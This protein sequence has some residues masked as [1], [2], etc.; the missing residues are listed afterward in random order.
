MLALQRPSCMLPRGGRRCLRLRASSV[1]SSSRS[2]VSIQ[3]ENPFTYTY[4]LAPA[5][6]SFGGGAGALSWVVDSALVYQIFPDRFYRLNLENDVDAASLNDFYDGGGATLYEAWDA[7]PTIRGFKGGTLDGI[8]AKLDYLSSIGVDVLYLCPVTQSAANHRYHPNDYFK[9]DDMLGG[10][11]ALKTLVDAAHDRGMRVVLDAVYNHTGRGFFAFQSLLENGEQ[12]PYA[13]WYFLGEETSKLTGEPKKVKPFPVRAYPDESA[14]EVANFRCW[15][16]IPELPTLN[17]ECEAVQEHLL[18][19]S[20][21]FL[22]DTFKVDGYRLDY[23]I[24]IPRDFWAAFREACHATFRD[25]HPSK[26]EVPWLVGEVF[27]LCPDWLGKDGAFDGTMNYALGSNLLGLAIQ[28]SADGLPEELEAIG[29]EYS[30]KPMGVE[31]FAVN[32]Q[33]YMMAYDRAGVAGE[34]SITTTAHFTNMNLLGSHD[35][36][37]V[38]TI[39]DGDGEAVRLAMS[40]M[41]TFPGA[42]MVFSGDEVGVEG[43]RDPAMRKGFPWHAQETWDM[44]TLEHVRNLSALRKDVEALRRGGFQRIEVNG[45]K[46]A[47]AFMRML[48]VDENGIVK[49]DGSAVVVVNADGADAC[50]VNVTLPEKCTAARGVDIRYGSETQ[51]ASIQGDD[52][53]TVRIDRVAQRS[54]AVVTLK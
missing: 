17:F 39:A 50:D 43:G 38:L 25:T 47:Y 1:P 44:Q 8:T 21:H 7:P 46:S 54:I 35:T 18:A 2:S 22:Q 24:D 15:W 9:V 23:P 49:A 20:E 32:V 41:F 26:N 33:S 19:A 34:E 29:G 31:E 28:P 5:G 45:A 12:S 3:G 51:A 52:S 4:R 48:D 27:G 30:I 14:G 6:K 36:P 40:L 16:N 13:D 37:R 10:D 42:P 53:K 11:D